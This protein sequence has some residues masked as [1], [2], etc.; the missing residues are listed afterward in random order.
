M[1]PMTAAA[2][3]AAAT[4]FRAFKRDHP[5]F[6]E[7][8]PAVIIGA[9]DKEIPLLD[10]TYRDFKHYQQF[11]TRRIERRERLNRRSA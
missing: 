1:T 5:G 2:R 8:L 9:E 6:L 7:N 11:I 4:R 3:R 10:A